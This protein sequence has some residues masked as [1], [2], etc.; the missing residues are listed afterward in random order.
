MLLLIRRG[1]VDRKAQ[2]QGWRS[3]CSVFSFCSAIDFAC[4]LLCSD[5][6]SICNLLLSLLSQA[7]LARVPLLL[8]ERL[9]A[10]MLD[11]MADFVFAGK[12]FAFLWRASFMK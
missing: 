3:V 10:V 1:S 9:A 2:P 12:S 6:L 11:C 7:A 5:F 8:N 4:V